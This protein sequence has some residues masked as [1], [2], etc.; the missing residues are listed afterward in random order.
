MIYLLE[1]KIVSH[2]WWVKDFIPI[3]LAWKWT[4]NYYAN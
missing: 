3:A 4:K 1:E 2:D